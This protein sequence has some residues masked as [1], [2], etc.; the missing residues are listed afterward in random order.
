MD[1]GVLKHMTGSQEVFEILAEWDLK[2]HMVL[3]DKSQL[4]IR[5]SSVAISEW[6]QDI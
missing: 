5:G 2:L 4:E 6:R 1:S 3:G